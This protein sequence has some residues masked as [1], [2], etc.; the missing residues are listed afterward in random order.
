MRAREADMVSRDVVISNPLGMH[1]RAAAKF[2]RLASGYKSRV[3]VG[4]ATRTMD[5]KSIM[6]LLLLSAAHGTVITVSAE[7]PDEHEA[8]ETLCGLVE[9]GFE[10][11]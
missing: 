6:G 1:A 11:R 8:L 7:G 2:V 5:G 9:A 4:R 10:E 3:L